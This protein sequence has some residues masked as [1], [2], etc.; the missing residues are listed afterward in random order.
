MNRIFKDNKR[1]VFTA[2]KEEFGLLIAD[3]P[4]PLE[5]RYEPIISFFTKLQR[6]TLP[7][8]REDVYEHIAG[9]L[10]V[11][12]V[13]GVK[14][15]EDGNVS[16]YYQA[17]GKI[18]PELLEK[19]ERLS[20][21]EKAELVKILTET[22][23]DK[24]GEGDCRSCIHNNCCGYCDFFDAT[25][26]EQERFEEHCVGCCCGDGVTCNRGNGCEN[27]EDGSETLQG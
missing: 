8:D 9:K 11:Y 22:K 17:K 3:F 25:K 2:T 16:I 15:M 14:H 6:I 4:Y 24:Y 20:K 10:D 23:T 18:S 7:H 19:I 5:V 21:E 12:R 27:W 13:L 26:S 1:H